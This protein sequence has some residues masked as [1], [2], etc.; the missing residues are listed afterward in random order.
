[1]HPYAG[2][3]K[4]APLAIM[5]C[6]DVSVEKFLDRWFLDCSAATQNI[7]LAAHA[8]GLG[9]VWVGIYPEEERIKEFQKLAA[10]PDTV[11]PLSLVPMEYSDK[12]A[13][14]RTGFDGIASIMIAGNGMTLYAGGSMRGGRSAFA[15]VQL[16]DLNMVG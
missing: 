3:V 16:I 1:M 2:M 8:L 13:A 5:V 14:K 15:R 7:L 9:A 10:L 4:E 11:I 6:G 12:K